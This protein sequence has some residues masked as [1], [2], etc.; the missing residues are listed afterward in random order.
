MLHTEDNV[1]LSGRDLIQ[2]YI[3]K[4]ISETTPEGLI[5]Q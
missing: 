3:V 2:L 1:F 4:N 5:V